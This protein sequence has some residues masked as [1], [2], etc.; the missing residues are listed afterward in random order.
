VEAA[1][2]DDF[3]LLPIVPADFIRE[4]HGVYSGTCVVDNNYYLQC[5]GSISYV[6]C[7]YRL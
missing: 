2:R 7:S 4:H 5:P 3:P 6:G 1:Q